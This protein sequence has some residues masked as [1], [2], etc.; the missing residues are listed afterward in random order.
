[1][2]RTIRNPIE[3]AAE[4]LAEV[5]RYL[6][7]VVE[8]LG[9]TDEDLAALL[10]RI[11]RIQIS[12]LRDVLE[13]GI[14]DF[15]AY[16]TDVAV[17]CLIY[18]FV[19]VIITW[20]A[21]ERD[22]IPLVFPAMSGF[23]LIGPFAAVGMYEMSRRREKGEKVSWADAFRFV[24][25]P[26]FVPIFI[27]GVMLV[28][29][30]GVWMLTAWAIYNITF[31]PEAPASIGIFAMD[32]LTTGAGWTMIALGFGVGFLFAALVLVI[33]VV[34]FPLLLDRPVGL[35]AAVITS[36]RVSALNAWPIAV[37]GL[38]VAGALAIA[39]IPLF[40]GLIV[41]IPILGHAT[42]HLYRKTMVPQQDAG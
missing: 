37:W 3:W 35:P 18:P 42:W 39:S 22:L 31:G 15:A 21:F 11:R 1:M 13:K 6:G 17:L 19:G 27:L 28:A 25:S 34:S 36:V 38:I 14:A 20:A 12:D 2:P 7:S 23:T 9:S 4:H 26:S 40:L 33:S 5:G 16:R 10:L 30:F 8:Q 29:I 41:V 32:V 24:G